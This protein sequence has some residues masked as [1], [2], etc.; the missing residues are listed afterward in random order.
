MIQLARSMLERYEIDAHRPETLR[1]VLLGAGPRMLG[2]AARRMDEINRAGGDIAALC[3][4]PLAPALNQ[5]DGLFTLVIRGEDA[6]GD[7]IRREQVVQCLIR[8]LH[9]EADFQSLM[10]A[11]S[12]PDLEMIALDAG[13]GDVELALLARMLYAR[14]AAGAEP[15]RLIELGSDF[16]PDAP[17]TLL[18][19]LAALGR[20][21]SGAFAAWLEGLSAVRVLADGLCGPMDDA[22]RA[23]CQREMNYRDDFIAWA[24]P[25]LNLCAERPLSGAAAELFPAGDFEA[26]CHMKARIF[27]AAVF[28]CAAPGF[29]C[30]LERFD[31][32]MGDAALRAWIGRAFADEI[33]PLLPWDREKIA[34]QVISAFERL[35]NPANP[36]PLLEVG[37]NLLGHL[38]RTLMP[39]IRAYARREFDAPPRLCM[40]LAAAIMLYA[41]V[42]RDEQGRYLLER[43]GGKRCPLVDRENLLKTFS[44]LDRDVPAE[45]LGYAVLADRELWGEDLR[46]MDGLEMRVVFA[47]SAIQRLGLRE[48]MRLAE[49]A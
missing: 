9:P 24:E 20:G 8:C 41:G 33:L 25:G 49:N 34:P 43:D 36:M 48:A 44:R 26:A 18:S 3:V 10:D 46:E 23:R 30:G 32:V 21:W 6:A 12:A 7:A 35:E 28:L 31:Q 2:A 4:T 39:A 27:D 1:A 15:V 42:R 16:D 29:L 19:A 38:P 14:W 40:A 11:M 47:L 45:A 37:Q 5:Q 13:A 22:E 17:S